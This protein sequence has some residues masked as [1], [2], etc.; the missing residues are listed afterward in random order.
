MTIAVLSGGSQIFN[1][2]ENNI[3]IKSNEMFILIVAHI[4][5]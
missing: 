5:V 4:C 1:I 3:R 2:T